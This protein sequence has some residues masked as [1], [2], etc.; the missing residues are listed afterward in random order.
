MAGF[1]NPRSIVPTHL[2]ILQFDPK[3]L[4]VKHPIERYVTA[5]GANGACFDEFTRWLVRTPRSIFRISCKKFLENHSIFFIH[6]HSFIHVSKLTVTLSINPRNSVRFI[7]NGQ[8]IRRNRPSLERSRNDYT[9]IAK[10]NV[11]FFNDD[12]TPPF[13][14]ARHKINHSL[15]SSTV[16]EEGAKQWQP[17]FPRKR[18]LSTDLE[19]NNCPPPK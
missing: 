12:F 13:M 6:C 14:N 1:S 7:E 18:I 19:T 2:K 8:K 10:E 17:Y 11:R 3:R 15:N 4:L 9:T 5:G 16:A